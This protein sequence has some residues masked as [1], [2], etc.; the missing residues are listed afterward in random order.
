MGSQCI[1]NRLYVEVDI[2][3][4]GTLLQKWVLLQ[5]FKAVVTFIIQWIRLNSF[6]ITDCIHLQNNKLAHFSSAA[7]SIHQLLKK[8]LWSNSYDISV[9]KKE[10]GYN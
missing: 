2:S 4:F 3:K 10:G 1:Q 8:V 5:W 7:N 6:L 9:L